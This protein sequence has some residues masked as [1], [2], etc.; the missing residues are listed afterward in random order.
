MIAL[1]VRVAPFEEEGAPLAH[2]AAELE[3]W[4][5]TLPRPPG[6]TIRLITTEWS[7]RRRELI[8]LSSSTAFAP[9]RVILTLGWTLPAIGDPDRFMV[10][11]INGRIDNHPEREET[12]KIKQT[13]ARWLAGGDRAAMTYIADLVGRW[14]AWLDGESGITAQFTKMVL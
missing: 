6:W 12:I 8:Q 10:V 2:L 7:L 9:Y 11:R 3:A 13:S 1:E 5:E 4:W 14:Q